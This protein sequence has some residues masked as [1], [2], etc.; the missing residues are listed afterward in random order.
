MEL[1]TSR[2]RLR[3]F[4]EVDYLALREKNCRPEKHT[5]ERELP[6]EAETR[7]FL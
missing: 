1:I 7:L 6:S 3:E 5:Y 2:L 4:A